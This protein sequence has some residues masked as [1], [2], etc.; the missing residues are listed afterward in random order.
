M[1]SVRFGVRRGIMLQT[2]I[3]NVSEGVCIIDIATY[4]IEYINVA[5]R[6]ILGINEYD[7]PG[8]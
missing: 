4:R 1:R 7:R 3:D 5:A 6:E 8:Y 2:I